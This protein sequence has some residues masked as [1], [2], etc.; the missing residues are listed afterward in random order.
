MIFL[1]L[2]LYVITEPPQYLDI[3]IS[4]EIQENQSS[5]LNHFMIWVSWFGRTSV[6]GIIVVSFSI[7]LFLL[8]YK[9]QAVLIICTLFSGAIGLFF[10]VIINRPRP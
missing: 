9:R 6:S 3:H 2:S 10:K 4:K 8:H 5:G 7:I 1:F